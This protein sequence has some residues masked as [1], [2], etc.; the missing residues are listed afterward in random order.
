MT[1]AVCT[2]VTAR[3]LPAARLLAASLR[4]HDPGLPL[5]VLLADRVDDR[6]DP[7]TESFR[8][9][10]L[11]E[12]SDPALAGRMAFYW[13]PVEFCC[14]LRGP[15]HR[16]MWEQ[17]DAD[18]WLYLD[19]DL[20]VTG[21]LGPLFDELDAAPV[22]LTPHLLG[23][24]SAD[25]APYYEA[26]LLRWG[27]HN[28]GCLGV[29]RTEVGRRFIDWF[30]DRLSLYAFDSGE[31]GFYLDQLWLNLVPQLFA[32]TRVSRDLGANV[33]YWNLPERPLAKAADGTVLSGGRPLTFFHFSGWDMAAPDRLARGTPEAFR[34]VERDNPVVWE[35]VAA[36]RAGL[37]EHGYADAAAWPYAFGQF[38]DGRPIGTWARRQYY[39]LWHANRWADGSPFAH[40]ERF[41]Q[42]GA[43]GRFARRC[44]PAPL[45]RGLRRLIAAAGA[46][47]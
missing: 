22:L 18:R 7:A 2:I 10:T 47:S 43:A 27:V 9:V 4:R 19:T 45:K 6:F 24:V 29:R 1:R 23:P 40:P 16:F 14:A 5:Y 41:R 35:L 33:A 36:Y 21:T 8:V 39:D 11:D 17:T 34:H 28:G 32:G 44:L 3:Y 46:G 20:L 42:G 38:D 37:L 25:L 15:L 13:T 31:R 30:A 26:H 12:L